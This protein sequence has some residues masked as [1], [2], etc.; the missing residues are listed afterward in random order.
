MQYD[1]DAIERTQVAQRAPAEAAAGQ[2]VRTIEP[3]RSPAEALE[4]QRAP[5]APRRRIP[6]ERFKRAGKVA[7]FLNGALTLILMLA[8]LGG[9]AFYGI[10]TMFDQPGPLGHATVLAIP[11]GEGANAIATRLEREGIVDDSRVFMAAVLWF[12]VKDKLKAGEYEIKKGASMR[13]VLNTLMEGKAI[14]YKV[15]IAEGL[16]SQQIVE[17][18]NEAPDLTGTVQAIP[19]EGSLLPD[20][21]KFAKGLSRQELIDRMQ[22]EQQKFV[23]T[24][25]EK[26]AQGVPVKTPEE[27]V[28]LASIIEKETGRADERDRVAAVFVNRLRSRMRLQSDPTIIYGLVGG[29]GSLGRGILRSEIDQRTA[30]NT[31]QIDGLPP[32]PICNPGRS[33]IE[34]TLNPAKSDDLYFVANGSGGHAFARTLE[35]HNRNVAQWR[36]IEKEAAARQR[37]AQPAVAPAT[38]AVPTP[39]PAQGSTGPAVITVPQALAPATAAAAA[40]AT[41]VPAQPAANGVARAGEVP[42]PVRKPKK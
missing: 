42:L 32:T 19:P 27:A 35:E 29:K 18:L 16:T 41:T 33:A 26:R 9:G 28:I 37:E 6:R 8:L 38:L 3:P 14:L 40:A 1:S 23:R 10:K 15:T 17:K 4:P 2:L 36:R 7:G 12:G 31:Y 20:T 30:Y 22:S 13:S 11:K 34:A 21:Y 5:A 25:W 24:L 39:E